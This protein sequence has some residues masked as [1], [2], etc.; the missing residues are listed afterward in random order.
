[1]K[2]VE[3]GFNTGDYNRLM[4]EAVSLHNQGRYEQAIG[5][6]IEAYD[7]APADT[8]E[9]GRSARD[10]GAAYDRLGDQTQS[11]RWA[12]EA[13]TLHDQ[14]ALNQEPHPTRDAYRER[15]VSAMYL[16]V[17][18]LRRAIRMD[19][20][21]STTM[22]GS[23]LNL[24]RQTKSDLSDAKKQAEG[25]NSH[26]DQYEINA[27]RRISIAESL[28][29]H[30]LTG[31]KLGVR[32]VRLAFKSE[33]PR[34]DTA[35]PNLSKEERSKAKIKALVGGAAAVAINILASPKLNWQRKL[36]LQLADRT[37]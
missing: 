32:A 28:Y 35:T 7:L 4:S 37:L 11:R 12:E 29:G 2:D 31:Y 17:S 13:Y 22:V 21:R 16:G 24:M 14:I 23:S 25:I 5:L 20:G 15:S 19:Q 26:V 30:R 10:I 3:E 34:L 36:A 6:R 27:M 1:M 33:S 8:L 18:G 9:K